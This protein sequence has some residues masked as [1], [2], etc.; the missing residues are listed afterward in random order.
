MAPDN[1]YSCNH[2][3]NKSSSR[4]ITS[5][6]LARFAQFLRF[7]KGFEARLILTNTRLCLKCIATSRKFEV[8]VKNSTSTFSESEDSVQPSTSATSNRE[9]VPPKESTPFIDLNLDCLASRSTKC[10]ICKAHTRT[11]VKNHVRYDIWLRRSIYVTTEARM[12]AKHLVGE[13]LPDEILDGISDVNSSGSFSSTN[14]ENLL[15]GL[16]KQVED[17]RKRTFENYLR[18][19]MTVQC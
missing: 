19:T 6:R 16:S 7:S 8:F 1:C 3:V 14:I 5:P 9:L 2:K 18:A 12:C 10:F 11:R 15:K 17:L 13:E 4:Y